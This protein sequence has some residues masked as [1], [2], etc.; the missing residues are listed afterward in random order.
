MEKVDSLD[1]GDDLLYSIH[2]LNTANIIV[3]GLGKDIAFYS[4]T[5]DAKIRLQHRFQSEKVKTVSIVKPYENDSLV[6]SA[7][8]EGVISVWNV[9]KVGISSKVLEIFTGS[10]IA[11]CEGSSNYI[12]ACLKPSSCAVFSSKSG[13]KL[14]TLQFSE[15]PSSKMML[16]SCFVIQNKLITLSTTRNSTYLNKWDIISNFSPIDSLKVCNS[17]AGMAKPS[18]SGETTAVGTG[19]GEIILVDM[20]TFSIK[21]KETVF[22]MPAT[23]CDFNENGSAVMVGSADYSYKLI[24]TGT[25]LWKVLGLLAVIVAFLSYFWA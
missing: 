17:S 20:K 4:V 5:E 19:S 25:S 8:E 9:E 18:R 3:G 15:S 2:Y 21:L 13:E 10:E 6:I 11:S 14:K 16:K 23:C 7:G 12:F 1:T 22:E 24:K